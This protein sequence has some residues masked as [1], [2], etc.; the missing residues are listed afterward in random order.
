MYAL[1]VGVWR[2]EFS[3]KLTQQHLKRKVAEGCSSLVVIDKSR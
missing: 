1:R 2:D 3:A